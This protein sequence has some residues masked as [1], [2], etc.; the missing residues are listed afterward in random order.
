MLKIS[1]S[2]LA[3]MK[4]EAEHT[5]EDGSS[6]SAAATSPPEG[7]RHDR[8]GLGGGAVPSDVARLVAVVAL[9][10]AACRRLS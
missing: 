10:R 2:K 1:M 9:D 8:P 5:S 6:T 4:L 3:N 7:G